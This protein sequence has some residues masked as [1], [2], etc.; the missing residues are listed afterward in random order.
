MAIIAERQLGRTILI[1][2]RIANPEDRELIASAFPDQS[3]VVVP[4]DP[5]LRAADVDGRA[6]ID[7]VPE[8]PA[9]TAIQQLAASL[10]K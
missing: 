1:A 10:V 9:V 5:G 2:N 3:P 4:E 7:T 6:P 8:S